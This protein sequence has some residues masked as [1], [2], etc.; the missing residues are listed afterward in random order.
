VEEQCVGAP[1]QFGGLGPEHRGRLVVAAQQREHAPRAG[2]PL[3]GIVHA[4]ELERE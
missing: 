3:R 2:E 1:A 4:L